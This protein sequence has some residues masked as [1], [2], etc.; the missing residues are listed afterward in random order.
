MS[1]AKG[2]THLDAEGQVH[3][4][5][6][7]EKAVTAR[8]A[9]ARA[10][11]RMLPD[12]VARL[13]AHDAPKGDVGASVRIAGIMAAK[14]TPD[15]IPLCHSLALTRVTVDVAWTDTGAEITA[16]AET[17]DRTGVEMEAM[18]AASVAAL[19]LYDMVKGMERGVSIER[20]ELI[21]KSGG[22]SGHWVRGAEGDDV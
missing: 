17:R 18:T 20:V 22:R 2:P 6:V 10:S 21:E 1:D 16:A 9:V 12:T 7:G 11:V 4:V 15:L 19:T 5:D 8:R 3:M 13:R 14:R